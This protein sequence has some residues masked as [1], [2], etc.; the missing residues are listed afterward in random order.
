MHIICNPKLLKNIRR[1][2]SIIHIFC[3]AGVKNTEMVGDMPVVGVVWYHSES[4]SNIL[5]VSLIKK[6]HQ[7]TYDSRLYNTFRVWNEENTK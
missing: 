3:S 5:S 4:I 7:V 2:D 6:D 1:T